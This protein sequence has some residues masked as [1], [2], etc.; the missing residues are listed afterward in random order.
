MYKILYKTM[1]N[2]ALVYIASLGKIRLIILVQSQI[3]FN[4]DANMNIIAKIKVMIN[5]YTCLFAIMEVGL[6]HEWCIVIVKEY[7]E[8]QSGD[9][10]RQLELEAF[11]FY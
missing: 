6:T 9:E 8:S 7:L 10:L 2:Y 1:S 11:D 3:L 5:K 4:V